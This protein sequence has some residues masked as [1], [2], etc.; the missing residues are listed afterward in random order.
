MPRFDSIYSS[1]PGAGKCSHCQETFS[2]S[3]NPL[4]NVAVRLREAFDQ[5]IRE[6]HPELLNEVASQKVTV[7]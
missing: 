3:L 1:D 2:V 7:Q 4:D 5:H 6:K